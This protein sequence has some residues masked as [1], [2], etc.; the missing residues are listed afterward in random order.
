MKRFDHI[1]TCRF[2]KLVISSGKPL[3]QIARESGLS[4]SQINAYWN[5]YANPTAFSL[6]RICTYF[7]VSADWMLGLSSEGGPVLEPR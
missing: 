7:H 5:D 1:C 3:A 6:K 2:R 4:G